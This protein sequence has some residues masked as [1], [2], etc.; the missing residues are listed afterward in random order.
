[1]GAL[2]LGACG[3]S[4][5]DLEKMSAS[6]IL[7]LVATDAAAQ[8]NVAVVISTPTTLTHQLEDRHHD[9][10]G[11]ST[12]RYGQFWAVRLRASGAASGTWYLKFSRSYLLSNLQPSVVA[13]SPSR[14]REV[15]QAARALAGNWLGGRSLAVDPDAVTV[16]RR[17]FG[18]VPRDTEAQ[19]FSPLVAA[20]ASVAAATTFDHVAAVPLRVGTSGEVLFVSVGADPLPL[21]VS[22]PVGAGSAPV[23]FRFRWP[24]AATIRAP[25]PL[26]T[27]CQL[28]AANAAA[29]AGLSLVAA[30]GAYATCG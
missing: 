9:V 17:A 16:A 25:R 29:A 18:A 22:L 19:L 30:A 21:A 13:G 10:S 28:R 8:P 3:S 5:P 11:Y 26:T 12:S 7:A 20:S 4:A 2:A 15:A 6:A 23:I 14:R 24:D 1:V 27:P